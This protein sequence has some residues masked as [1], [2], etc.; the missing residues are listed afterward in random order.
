MKNFQEGTIVGNCTLESLLDA[1]QR[2]KYAVN[3]CIDRSLWKKNRQV[4]SNAHATIHTHTH[5]HIHTQHAYISKRGF[6]TICLI[7]GYEQDLRHTK[8]PHFF[9]SFRFYLFPTFS[10]FL[11]FFSRINNERNVGER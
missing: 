6:V 2:N 3:A 10:F 1:I 9:F 11:F 5:T 8:A 7:F 4:Q